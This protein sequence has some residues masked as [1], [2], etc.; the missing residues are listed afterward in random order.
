MAHDLFMVI[1]S[2]FQH[3]SVNIIILWVLDQGVLVEP[4]RTNQKVWKHQYSLGCLDPF[5]QKA[6]SRERV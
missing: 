1:Y 6:K 5:S 2:W 3:Q 4:G